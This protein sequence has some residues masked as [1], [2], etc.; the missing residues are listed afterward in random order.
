MIIY[1][2]PYKQGL[3]ISSM[4]LNW[5][6]I[7]SGEHKGK[8]ATHEVNLEYFTDVFKDINYEIVDLDD[9]VFQVYYIDKPLINGFRLIQVNDLYN[10]TIEIHLMSEDTREFKTLK[11]DYTDTWNDEDVFKYVGEI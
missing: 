7:L 3:V 4:I 1:K 10:G 11:M 2:E 8:F 9:S 6:E 5:I